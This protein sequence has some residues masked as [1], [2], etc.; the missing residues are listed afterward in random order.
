ML[1]VLIIIIIITFVVVIVITVSHRNI[2]KAS[3]KLEGKLEIDIKMCFRHVSE[4]TLKDQKHKCA[5]LC[6]RDVDAPLLTNVIHSEQ[7][8]VT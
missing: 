8:F 7:S 3:G 6:K 1:L 4:N 2:D 5:G